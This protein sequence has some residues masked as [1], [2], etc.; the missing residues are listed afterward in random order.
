MQSYAI[1]DART[2]GI[3]N[4]ISN[5]NCKRWRIDALRK[6]VSVSVR[7]LFWEDNMNQ[8]CV[9]RLSICVMAMILIFGLVGCSSDTE[10]IFI[11]DTDEMTKQIHDGMYGIERVKITANVATIADGYFSGF[12]DLKYIEVAEDNEKYQSINGVLYTKDG[13]ALV[14]YPMAKDENVYTIPDEC[15]AVY[16]YAFA[17]SKL[18]RIVLSDEMHEIG[19]YSFNNCDGLTSMNIPRKVY[20]ISAGAFANCDNLEFLSVDDENQYYVDIDGVLF[21][22]QKDA[23]HTYPGGKKDSSY[24][25][26]DTCKTIREYSFSGCLYLKEVVM[27]ENVNIGDNAF[28]E[29]DIEIVQISEDAINIEQ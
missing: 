25:L 19:Y 2:P 23:L 3:V 4:I 5:K 27:S 28:L 16:S 13:S 1:L 22:S 24:V 14:A 15:V 29:S 20:Y 6:N 17:G 9:R 12:Y 21:N 8:K 18:E 10:D 26:P 7:R 11:L